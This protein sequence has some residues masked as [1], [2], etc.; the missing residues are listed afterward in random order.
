[1]LYE[2]RWNNTQPLN[3]E[4]ISRI[5]ELYTV[6]VGWAQVIVEYY[7]AIDNKKYE[8]YHEMM[9]DFLKKKEVIGVMVN[10]HLFEKDPNA[11]WGIMGISDEDPEYIM[12]SPMRG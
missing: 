6:S 7:S 12:N 2:L 1:M 10:K 8:M 11:V 3:F 5:L 4:R 9:Q